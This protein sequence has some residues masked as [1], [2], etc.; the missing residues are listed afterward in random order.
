MVYNDEQLEHWARS[1]PLKQEG[2][3]VGYG[4]RRLL[5]ENAALRAQV[6][7]Q[8]EL[9]SKRAERGCGIHGGHYFAGGQWKCDCGAY[10]RA[11]FGVSETEPLPRA[12]LGERAE[13]PLTGE[14]VLAAM[15]SEMIHE[16]VVKL[17]PVVINCK[18]D[19]STGLS[20][21]VAGRKEGNGS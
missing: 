9:L 12:R 20:S 18:F 13:K 5:A 3:Y 14:Q 6:A 11:D 7:A 10:T 16:S 15:G 4:I 21:T 8:S 2:E 1:Q 17:A 19:G